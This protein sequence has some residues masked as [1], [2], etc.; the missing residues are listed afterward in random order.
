MGAEVPK[1]AQDVAV[2]DSLGN[3]LSVLKLVTI[4]E[5]K[6]HGAMS[7]EAADSM[8]VQ[9][10]ELTKGPPGD[11]AIPKNPLESTQDADKS[12][13]LAK[14]LA[15]MLLS[16]LATSQVVKDTKWLETG[17]KKA[18]TPTPVESTRDTDT[19]VFSELGKSPKEDR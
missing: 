2:S 9:S 7:G 12:S 14:K 6:L 19:M 1:L 16:R 5:D 13:T 8:S 4:K 18:V 17:A 11:G 10:Q 15:V 3:Q